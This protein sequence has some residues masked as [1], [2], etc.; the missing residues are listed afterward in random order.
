MNI[1]RILYSIII[2]IVCSSGSVQAESVDVDSAKIAEI[3]EAQLQ[4]QEDL[5]DASK[6]LQ[7]ANNALDKYLESGSDGSKGSAKSY[8]IKSCE[9]VKH[10]PYYGEKDRRCEQNYYR[11]MER[12]A[13]Y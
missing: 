10:C 1:F 6:R 2:V 8:C 7:Q 5:V 12:C 13:R 3:F 4:A 9:A 11:C